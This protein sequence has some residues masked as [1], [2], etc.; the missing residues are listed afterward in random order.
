MA[1][2][3]S[4]VNEKNARV[5]AAKL[6]HKRRTMKALQ[7]NR[8]DIAWVRKRV[9]LSMLRDHPDETQYAKQRL[10]RL[11]EIQDELVRRMRKYK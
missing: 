8:D 6:G 5:Q 2:S 1:K 3:T 7:E 4:S 9:T 11:L 10:A